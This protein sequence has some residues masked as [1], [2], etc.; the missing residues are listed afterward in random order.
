MRL[1]PIPRRS[2]VDQ[3]VDSILAVIKQHN[4]LPGMRL[5][6]E[7]E[8]LEQ[9]QVSRPSLREALAR[10]DSMGLFNIQRG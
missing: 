5:P 3:V 8:L 7:L 9:L 1:K 10:L 2:T 6:G 4:L